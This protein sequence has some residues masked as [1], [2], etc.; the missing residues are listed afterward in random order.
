MSSRQQT[1]RF[2]AFASYCALVGVLTVDLLSIDRLQPQTRAFLW[3]MWVAP[4]LLFLPGM[5]RG[6]WRSYL[7]LC[8]V[9]CMYFMMA[10]FNLFRPQRDAADWAELL[11]VVVLFVSAMMYSRWRQREI[12][13]AQE[14]RPVDG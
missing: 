8:F 5:L 2:L 10:V 1:A 12:A 13:A 11:L 7:W 9:S 3:A 14:E 6:S 4:L